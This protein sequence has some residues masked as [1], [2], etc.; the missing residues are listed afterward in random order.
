[1]QLIPHID[2]FTNSLLTR[3]TI[4]LKYCTTAAIGKHG[5]EFE[6][7]YILAEI[8]NYISTVGNRLAVSQKKKMTNLPYDPAVP[9]T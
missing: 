8:I 9:E 4:I 5:K 1:M 3:M 2:S 6:Q 7:L